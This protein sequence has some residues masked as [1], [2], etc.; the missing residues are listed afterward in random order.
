MYVMTY[1]P[2][3]LLAVSDPAHTQADRVIS[4]WEWVH[5]KSLQLG[6]MLC[7][8]MDYTPPGS[9]VCEI[10]QARILEWIAMPSSGGSSKPRDQTC[11]SYVYCIGRQVLYH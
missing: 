5:A 11:V 10:L 9:S 1:I 6:P 4:G 2:L 7:N 8:P 3:P